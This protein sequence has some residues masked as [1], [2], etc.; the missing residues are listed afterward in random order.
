MNDE[1][2]NEFSLLIAQIQCRNVQVHNEMFVINWSILLAVSLNG[3][4]GM[5]DKIKEFSRR[6]FRLLPPIWSSLASL[7]HPEDV[8]KVSHFCAVFGCERQRR[9][10]ANVC[11]I[12]VMEFLH[13]SPSRCCSETSFQSNS[14]PSMDNTFSAAAPFLR[15]LNVVGLFP[16]SSRDP[17]R[18]GKF[19]TK[20]SDILSTFFLF[21]LL[22]VSFVLS[23]VNE[24][25]MRS[26]S[27]LLVHGWK[28]ASCSVYLS[29]LVIVSYQ[30]SRSK[31]VVE[32]LEIIAKV[33]SKVKGVKVS[34]L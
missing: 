1:Q 23:V 31:N 17:M 7:L 32:L 20:W 4:Y 26:N 2:R 22:I 14:K 16:M 25:F 11:S 18:D 9:S 3:F 5:N 24:G 8:C 13:Q 21:L 30:V 33:D 27:S 15:F 10:K 12:N 28:I 34:R 6:W 29:M 19:S